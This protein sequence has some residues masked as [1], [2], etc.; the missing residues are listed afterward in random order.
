MK[1]SVKLA[2]LLVLTS[3]SAAFVACSDSKPELATGP[4]TTPQASIVTNDVDT[5]LRGYLARN[6][7]TGRIGRTLETRL[8]RRVDGQL[9]DIGRVLWFD[10]IH[11]L[12]NDNT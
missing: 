9:A 6:G 11:G 3:F 7:F 2:R 4:A 1:L 12:N 10:R 5:A 8:G